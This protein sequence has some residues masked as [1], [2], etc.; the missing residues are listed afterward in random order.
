MREPTLN[1]PTH[2]RLQ[3]LAR[4]LT[5]PHA[6]PR[7]LVTYDSLLSGENRA[8]APGPAGAGYTG[9]HTQ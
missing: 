6:R 9:Q 1:T 3:P 2:R 4:P 5:R 7:L 8:I